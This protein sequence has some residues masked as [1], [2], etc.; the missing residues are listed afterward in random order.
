MLSNKLLFPEP[1]DKHANQNPEELKWITVK[2]FNFKTIKLK[3]YVFNF[4]EKMSKPNTLTYKY[5]HLF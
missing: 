4:H 2:V 5:K 1:D 3:N